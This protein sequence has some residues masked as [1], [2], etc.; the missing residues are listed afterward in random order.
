[1]GPRASLDDVEKIKILSIPGLELQPVPIPA[2][3][4][5][6]PVAKSS[7]I[8]FLSRDR[9]IASSNLSVFSERLSRKFVMW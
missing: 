5:T 7:F 6:K 3:L 8:S 4:D 9:S 1:M 2:P